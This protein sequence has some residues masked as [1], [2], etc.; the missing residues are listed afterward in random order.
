MVKFAT[1]AATAAIASSAWAAPAPHKEWNQDWNHE[2]ENNWKGQCQPWNV[3]TRVSYSSLSQWE[4]KSYIAGI[5]CIQSKPSN[6]D[7]NQFPAA[8]NRYQDYSTIHVS[9]T[10]KVHLSG[11][12]LTWHRYYLYLFEKDMR[13]NCGYRGRFPYWDFSVPGDITKDPIFDGSDTSLSGNG[14]PNG[15]APIA[16][17]PSLVIPHGSG[18]G[19]VTSGPFKNWMPTLDFISPLSLVSGQ[20]LPQSAY[21]YKPQ[22]LVRDL[23]QYVKDTYETAALVSKTVQSRSAAELELNFNSVIGGSSLGVHSGGHFSVGG[24]MS[25]I[26]VSVQDPSW[27]ALHTMIDHVYTSW[28]IRNPDIATQLFGT[29]TANNAPPSPNVTLDTIE[30][31]WG[32]FESAAIPVRNLINT[33]GGPFCYQYDKV[34]S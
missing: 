9:Q 28:Q 19:C 25:S 13:Q 6:L 21:D 24:F 3:Q 4:K 16:L 17:G 31:G 18:G 10:N 32:Y 2:W 27:W 33:K 34:L 7:R 23:N 15:T 30:P 22:C 26:H 12:F 29:Q 20:P 1:L 8:V 14:A 11:F 5:Q